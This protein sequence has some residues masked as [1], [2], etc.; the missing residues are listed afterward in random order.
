MRP[1]PVRINRRV[2]QTGP[3]LPMSK[4][5]PLNLLAPRAHRENTSNL[6]RCLQ[7][8]PHPAVRHLLEVSSLITSN[9]SGGRLSVFDGRNGAI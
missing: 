7:L 8:T 4:H 1:V 2:I 3:Q 5:Q 9:S 6:G